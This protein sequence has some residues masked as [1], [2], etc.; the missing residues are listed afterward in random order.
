[1]NKKQSYEEVE[2]RLRSLEA[3]HLE[4][5]QREKPLKEK[6]TRYR[7]LFE[8]AHDAI[9][10]MKTDRY[11]EC[12]QQ[13]LKIFGC[14]RDQ[15]LNKSPLT[16]SPK[17][18]PD[19]TDSV[20]A[21]HEKIQLALDGE[22]QFF[23][24]RHIR[25]DGTPFDAEVSL[26]RVQLFG[27][28]YLQS[29][30]RD[31][32]DRKRAEAELRGSSRSLTAL[33]NFVPYPM[34]VLTL[35][36]NVNFI[37]PAF[38][39][40]F[41]WE[42]S[43]LEGTTIPYLLPS[44]E[45]E[46]KNS[47][48]KLVEEGVAVRQET[49]RL[50]KD[51]RILDVIVRALVYFET[52]N[53]PL[54]IMMIF[55]DISQ[56][57]RLTRH[58]DAMQRISMALPKYPDLE[59]LLDYISNEIKLL[60]GS[61]GALV[62]LLDEEKNELF[63]I[64]VAHDDI[65]T[66]KVAKQIRYPADSQSVSAKVVKTGKP[67]IVPD[68]SQYPNYSNAIDMK[69]GYPTTDMVAVPLTSGEQIVGVLI[70]LNK[71]EGAF[72]Q[73]DVELLNVIGSTVA[74]SIINARFSEEIKKAYQE[75]SSLNR[76]KSKVINHLSHE[77]K[78]PISILQSSINILGKKLSISSDTSWTK[79]LERAN[80]NLYRLVDIQ[81]QAED[82]IQN[83]SLTDFP[84]TAALLDRSA[85]ELEALFAEELG[86]GD[87]IGRI[88][89]RIEGLYGG[90]ELVSE[91][92]ALSRY[93]EEA[94]T[95]FMPMF[96]HRD[97]E[98]IRRIEDTPMICIPMESLKNIFL[99]LLRN[100]VEN[101]PDQGKIIITVRGKGNGTELVV[102][103]YGIGITQDHQG[104]IF[105]GF[106]TTR[107]T[108]NYSSKRPFDFGA[109]GKGADLLRMKVFSE[110]YHFTL[111]MESTRCKYIPEGKDE[112]PGNIDQCGFCT[113]RQDCYDVGGTSFTLF[114]PFISGCGNN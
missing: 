114:F 2:K 4:W 99:G 102:R 63:F 55:R 23:E 19:G 89:Q 93:V 50:T 97:V 79:T 5:K 90:R 57:K 51:G 70:A 108:M 81:Y 49:R 106:F 32:T 9:F 86:E 105:D 94:L 88:R 85:D 77:L 96:S 100:A 6:E 83:K 35:E 91:E 66:E 29:I 14:T 1:M 12:N 69:L 30:V 13:T 38:T 18:Q 82:I 72:E 44:H 28:T 56:E 104:R 15:I 33:F 34:A 71:K 87:I 76:A 68:T 17:M 36:G 109:G 48:N 59:N 52:D 10:M 46:I 112:C 54:G 24:W 58:N 39:E 16:F 43:E 41:G 61:Q 22:P 11:V 53:E 7:T 31:V 74:L 60:L 95:I 45:S 107:E 67:I 98:I 103:D 3:E 75:V 101:T 27:D 62:V 47:M 25:Y 26:N 111:E 78:T 73:T 40:T 64:G 110:R 37:N 8:T 80:R 84:G 113:S 20:T 65:T 92:I 42:L 21:A